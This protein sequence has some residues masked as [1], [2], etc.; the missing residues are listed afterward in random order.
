MNAHN[1]GWF[2]VIPEN[3]KFPQK[4]CHPIS[5][6]CRQQRLFHLPGRG[7]QTH[8]DRCHSCLRAGDIIGQTLEA[9]WLSRGEL[10]YCQSPAHVVPCLWIKKCISLIMGS[11]VLFR[12]ALQRNRTTKNLCSYTKHPGWWLSCLVVFPCFWNLSLRMILRFNQI[13][14]KSCPHSKHPGWWLSCG[15]SEPGTDGVSRW[16][17]RP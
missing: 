13:V 12:G 5:Q 17:C 15:A 8:L 2:L 7:D 14:P 1:E 10:V 3:S 6:Q 4:H 16:H 9:W 11:N